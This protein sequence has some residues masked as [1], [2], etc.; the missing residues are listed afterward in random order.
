MHHTDTIAAEKAQLRRRIAEQKM[1]HTESLS[2]RSACCI[3]RFFA[4]PQLSAARVVLLYHSL[5]DE[6][7]THPLAD[8]LL[9]EGKTVL[10]PRVTGPAS[11]ELRRYTGAASLQ[12]GAYGIMEPTGP[13]WTQPDDVDLVLVP[14][15]AFDRAGRRLGRGR[16]YY[17]RMLVRM[18]RTLKVGICFDFQLVESV[19]VS[20]DDVCMDVVVMESEG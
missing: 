3:Q 14:G 2:W 18:P 19:P 4:L 16:G 17:D 6:V 10:L 15:V 9:A 12:P 11:M 1:Q 5:P 7:C 13:V 8:R 20:P